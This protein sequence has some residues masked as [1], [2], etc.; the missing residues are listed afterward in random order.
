MVPTTYKKGWKKVKLKNIL[1]AFIEADSAPIYLM[2]TYL[3]QTKDLVQ[4]RAN[5][6]KKF[7][8]ILKKIMNVLLS[9]PHLYIKFHG[10][11][12]LTLKITKKT[13]FL[14][15]VMVQMHLKF[16]LFVTSRVR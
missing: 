5:L 3:V 16:V 13:N 8:K 11:I 6:L 2:G 9:L 12:H 15:T 14:T 7:Q 10:Q 1:P 4:T